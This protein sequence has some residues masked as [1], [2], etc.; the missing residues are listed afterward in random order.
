[1]TTV[2][3]SGFY[4]GLPV[5]RDFG[6]VT[7]PGNFA[8]LP[9]DWHVATC[10][11]PNSTI[12]VQ[13]GNYKHV[14]TVG[15]AAVTAVLNAA[16][17]L[18][19]RFVFEGDGSAFCVPPALLEDTKAALVKTQEMAQKSFGLE[20]RVAALPVEHVRKAGLDIRVARARVG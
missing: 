18:D 11:V 17:E 16:G 9:A 20:L 7:E 13:A 19:I 3:T 1:M 15:A 6:G 14:N 5:R 8:P 10:D 2:G 12:A 4:A